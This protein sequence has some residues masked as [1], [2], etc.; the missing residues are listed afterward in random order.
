MEKEV[1][2]NYNGKWI[3][4]PS[5]WI[6][7]KRWLKFTKKRWKIIDTSKYWI[8]PEDERKYHFILSEKEYEES[9][10]L[11]KEEHRTLSYEFYPCAGL[12]YGIRVHDLKTEEIFDITTYDN[13]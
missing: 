5:K 13:W 3:K 8:I 12:G 6:L 11:Y 2:I 10:R 1:W 7:F 4:N 9:E